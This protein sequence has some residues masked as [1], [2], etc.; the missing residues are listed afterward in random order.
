MPTNLF[1][2][3]RFFRQ[4][5]FLQIKNLL[6]R[7]F[8]HFRIFYWN[9][10]KYALPNDWNKSLEDF[11]SLGF[12]K[13]PST[14]LR[15]DITDSFSRLLKDKK[16]DDILKQFNDLCGHFPSASYAV[17]MFGKLYTDNKLTAESQ[18]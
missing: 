13:V 7:V 3:I 11:R 9:K 14:I 16:Y 15:P 1:S 6:P 17:D 10:K 8:C 18:L 12:A 2:I 4:N 5:L